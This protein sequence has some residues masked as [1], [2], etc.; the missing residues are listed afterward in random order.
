MI[1]GTVLAIRKGSFTVLD[2]SRTFRRKYPKEWRILTSRFGTYGSKRRYTVTTYLS[3][4]L[5][6]YSQ[7]T[8]SL[9][10]PFVRFKEGRFRGYRR[11]T[12]KEK[13][14][15]GSPWIAVFRKR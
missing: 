5:D 6:Q 8:D 2:F 12:A 9:L 14:V 11:T 13:C 4:R 7:K 3:N 15:F 1:A 10:V